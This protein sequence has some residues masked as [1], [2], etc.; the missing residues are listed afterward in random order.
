LNVPA[1]R[2]APLRVV[3]LWTEEEPISRYIT[4]WLAMRK[5]R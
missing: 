4:S 1:A 2:I 5:M 3:F